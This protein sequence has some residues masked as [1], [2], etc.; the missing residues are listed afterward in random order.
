MFAIKIANAPC[1][2]WCF[3]CFVYVASVQPLVVF[4]AWLQ[5][6]KFAHSKICVKEQTLVNIWATKCK[7]CLYLLPVVMWNS[8][9]CYLPFKLQQ[10]NEVGFIHKVAVGTAK[11]HCGQRHQSH[12][13]SSQST[14][15]Q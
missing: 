10:D 5:V 7:A 11:K 9:H 15:S 13:A 8:I 12:R 2:S 14:L 6:I 1:K 4:E 3:F